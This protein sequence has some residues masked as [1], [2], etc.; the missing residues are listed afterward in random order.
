MT[1]KALKRGY[2]VLLMRS[3]KCVF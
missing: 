3:L 1:K 2:S